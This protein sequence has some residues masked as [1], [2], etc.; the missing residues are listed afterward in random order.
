MTWLNLSPRIMILSLTFGAFM[1]LL[2]GAVRSRGRMR[3]II[4]YLLMLSFPVVLLAA[5]EVAASA[6]TL[7]A[8]LPLHQ[9]LSI[10]V[11]RNGWPVHFMSAE[12]KVEKDGLHLYRP[13]RGDGIV[14]NELGLRTAL[15][16]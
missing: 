11:N 1:L 12:R 9:D 10:L 14:I 5:M 8:R 16:T 6:F 4:F 2:G 13:W 15:S 7:A 3:V